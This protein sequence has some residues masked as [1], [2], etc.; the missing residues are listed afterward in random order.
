MVWP[1]YITTEEINSVILKSTINSMDGWK[2]EAL[3]SQ[4]LKEV[5]RREKGE[6]RVDVGVSLCRTSLA[7]DL[8]AE[9]RL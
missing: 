4:V 8:R 6:E 9:S 7:F 3:W 2:K 5:T 1:S